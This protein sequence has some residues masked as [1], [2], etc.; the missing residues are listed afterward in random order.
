MTPERA[1]SPRR[2]PADCLHLTPPSSWD[3][4]VR[5]D[6]L[7]GPQV[8]IGDQGRVI[9]VAVLLE[10]GGEV[11]SDPSVVPRLVGVARAL[12]S[13]AGVGKDESILP[14]LLLKPLAGFG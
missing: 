6:L 7:G 9:Q 8:V 11:A 13:H 10:H 4:L 2:H 12:L 14:G 5:Q 3:A 1:S